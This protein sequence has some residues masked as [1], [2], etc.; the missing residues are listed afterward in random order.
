[1]AKKFYKLP[2]LPYA[3]NAL[4]PYIS[5]EQ[6]TIHHDKHHKTYVDAANGIL[7]LFDESREKGEDFDIKGK[8]KELSFNM[9]GHQLHKLFWENM[10]PASENGGEP[11]GK[12]AEYINDSFG[13]FERF[14]KEFSQTAITTE[15]SGWAVLVFCKSTERLFV[16]QYEKHNV[17]LVP[18]W[19]PLLVLDVWEHAYYLD[20]KNV[21]PDFV[22]A[23]WNIVNWDAAN[24]RLE[25]WISSTI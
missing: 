5:E 23:F 14:K 19:I 25:N 13:S 7:K 16:L 24:M 8:A 20:Y 15:G 22:E 21:R 2:D 1:M 11:T 12:I 9:G 18:R 3:Y 17:N 4:E 6:L 10:G